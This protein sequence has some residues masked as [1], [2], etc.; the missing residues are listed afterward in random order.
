MPW[1]VALVCPQGQG[2][3]LGHRVAS[4]LR[5]SGEAQESRAR[6]EEWHRLQG[7]LA[8][9]GDTLESPLHGQRASRDTQAVHA[10]S[11]SSWQ[12]GQK[13]WSP[14]ESEELGRRLLWPLVGVM[15]LS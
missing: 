10:L 2:N 6:K 13:H 9:P 4:L 11:C 12:V 14:T 15:E 7:A 1:N 3:Y 8:W 5:G